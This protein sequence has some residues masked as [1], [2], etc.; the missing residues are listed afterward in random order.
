MDPAIEALKNGE[1]VLAFLEGSVNRTLVPGRGKTGAV[2]MA[3]ATGAPL[4]PMALWGT[5]RIWAEQGQ[6]SGGRKRHRLVW[7]TPVTVKIGPPVRID[8]VE[9]PRQATDRVMEIIRALLR[10]AQEEDPAST[11]PGPT[12][13]PP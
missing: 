3:Q 10:D 4:I 2:R 5:H 13:G 8:P 6:G 1:V 12:Q 9:D 7:R 11:V